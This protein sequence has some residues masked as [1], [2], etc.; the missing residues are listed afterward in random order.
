MVG[1]FGRCPCC[2]VVAGVW[3]LDE[4]GVSIRERLGM[5]FPLLYDV[6]EYQC[7][8]RQGRFTAGM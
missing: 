8:K 3:V 7:G 1:L 2:E 5:G 6:V 4:D